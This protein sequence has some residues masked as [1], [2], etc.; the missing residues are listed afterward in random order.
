VRAAVLAL[1]C[2]KREREPT[3]AVLALFPAKK[4]NLNEIELW[5]S[6]LKG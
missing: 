6:T 1:A 5:T 3:S 2:G 4:D